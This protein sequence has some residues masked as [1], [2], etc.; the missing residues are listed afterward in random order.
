MGFGLTRQSTQS[1]LYCLI[2]KKAQRLFLCKKA[3]LPYLIWYD[4]AMLVDQHFALE[5]VI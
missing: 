5:S 3:Y 4:L 2:Q 1:N